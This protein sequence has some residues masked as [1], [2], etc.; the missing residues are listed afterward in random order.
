MP[1]IKIDTETF[2]EPKQLENSGHFLL[3]KDGLVLIEIQGT[4]NKPTELPGNF[5]PHDF[6]EISGGKYAVKIGKLKLEIFSLDGENATKH[7]KHDTK[8]IELLIGKNQK[9][10]GEIRKLEKPL[11]VMKFPA[12]D[13]SGVGNQQFFDENSIQLVDIV[14][15]KLLFKNRPVPLMEE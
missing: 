3:K 11:G 4:I 15:Y 9:L 7:Q 10:V 12:A 14:R 1:Q 13:V 2:E 8:K 5:A 6:V